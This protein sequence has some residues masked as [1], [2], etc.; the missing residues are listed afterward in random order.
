M[1]KLKNVSICRFLCMKI[2][3]KKTRVKSQ[4]NEWEG[5]TALWEKK[6]TRITFLVFKTFFPL[7]WVH[8]K[9]KLKLFFIITLQFK[10]IIFLLCSNKHTTFFLSLFIRVNQSYLHESKSYWWHLHI[11]F[12]FFV[13]HFTMLSAAPLIYHVFNV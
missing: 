7:L 1:H 4:I 12:A 5:E 9:C 3:C 8:M 6:K 2:K 13:S 10:R 11:H